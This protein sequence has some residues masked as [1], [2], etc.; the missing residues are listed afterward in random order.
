MPRSFWAENKPAFLYAHKI[1]RTPYMTTYGPDTKDLAMSPMV[2]TYGTPV[3]LTGTVVEQ[4]LGG[5]VLQPIAAAEYFIDSPGTDGTGT[6]MLAS[7]GDWGAT[8]EGVIGT[9]ETCGLTP[10]WHY[11]LAH[12]RNDNGDWGPFTAIFMEV[13]SP[14]DTDADGTVDQDDFGVTALCLTGPDGSGPPT[15]TSSDADCDGDIDLADVAV[16]A[17]LFAGP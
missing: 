9:I 4:R 6:P 17:R 5:D 3:A 1:A 8:S 12:G 14:G 10:G 2:A 7:D 15:C 13:K 16:I 11:V